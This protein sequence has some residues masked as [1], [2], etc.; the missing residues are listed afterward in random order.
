VSR[1]PVHVLAL[2]GGAVV[3]VAAFL[4]W[5]SGLGSANAFDVPLAVLWTLHPGTG[6]LDLGFMIV[7]LGAL[8]VLLAFVPGVGAGRRLLG[9]LL[10][11][12]AVD[13]VVQIW[14]A[15]SDLGGG[16]GDVFDVLGIAAY[17]TLVGGALVASSK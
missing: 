9:V 2:I 1:R 3:V 8:A 7:A 6:G 5:V 4:P 12:V 16:I 14:R 15:V 10:V 13:Y 17:V 11:G